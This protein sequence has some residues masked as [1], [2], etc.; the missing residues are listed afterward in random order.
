MNERFVTPVRRYPWYLRWLLNL[1]QKQ[2]HHFNV[3]A[4]ILEGSHRDISVRWCETCG[5]FCTAIEGTPTPFR[6]PEPSYET[7]LSDPEGFFF[8]PR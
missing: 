2:C 4:D 3:K 8:Q 6:T 7:D 1:L 5:A